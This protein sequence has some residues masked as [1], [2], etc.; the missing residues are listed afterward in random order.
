[1]DG[2]AGSRAQ[3][4]YTGQVAT[5]CRIPIFAHTTIKQANAR[6]RHFAR[7][8]IKSLRC[9]FAH[10]SV[11]S[12]TETNPTGTA[13]I[14]ASIEYPAG[15]F[16]QILFS[17][18]SQATMAAGDT[19]VSD[20]CTVSIPTG[21][22]FF[23]RTFR[24]TAASNFPMIQSTTWTIDATNGDRMA[25]AASGLSDQTMSGSITSNQ[26]TLIYG[27]CAIVAQTR[28]PSVFIIGDS[29][30][31]GAFDGNDGSTDRGESAKTIGP[32]F[33]YSA[34]CS[35]GA[36]GSGFVASHTKQVALFNLGYWSHV[37]S[38]YGINDSVNGQTLV[39]F[40]A[41]VLA[42]C[43]YF[44]KP[45]H[46]TTIPPQTTSS[47]SWATVANQTA[48]ATNA[49]RLTYNS[50]LLDGSIIGPAKVHD[51]ALALSTSPL[52][53]GKWKAPAEI[54]SAATGDGIHETVLGYSL[55]VTASSINTASITR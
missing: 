53:V 11:V 3:S 37:F 45:V 25:T 24:T 7:D 17:G 35:P 50:G 44:N 26:T 13:T 2:G 34:I 31:F 18:S 39:Q 14:T 6:E 16:T 52:S 46:W 4:L 20:L 55:P 33:G 43:G 10:W 21:D 42:I 32:L 29:R 22:A 9:V 23:V 8:D 41:T 51:V 38:N 54:A 19:L 1:M 12:G 28:K 30:N 40:T 49:V 27:P 5:G 15:V 36:L 47:D 48:H